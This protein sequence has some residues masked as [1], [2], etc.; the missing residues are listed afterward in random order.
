M[1]TLVKGLHVEPAELVGAVLTIQMVA[2]AMFNDHDVAEWTVL[3]T[4][5]TLPH[6]ELDIVLALDAG[7]L[8][9][10]FGC[11]LSTC[12]ADNDSTFAL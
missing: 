11:R 8:L 7:M 4:L 10:F 12:E 2:A 6:L 9:L 3:A 5:L 1:M